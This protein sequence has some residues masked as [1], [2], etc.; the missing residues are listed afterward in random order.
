M[1][2]AAA[3]AQ[4]SV[5]GNVGNVRV[6]AAALVTV[7]VAVWLSALPQASVP[8]YFTVMVPPAHAV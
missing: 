6:G 3:S 7:M 4:V 8:S 1:V 2:K 5:V